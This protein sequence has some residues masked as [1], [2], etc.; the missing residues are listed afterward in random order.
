M[1]NKIFM[2]KGLVPLILAG[3]LTLMANQECE[4]ASTPEKT[5][6]VKMVNYF[7]KIPSVRLDSGV[8]I[9][10]GDFDK[11]GDLDLIEIAIDY[12]TAE[13]RS[14]F[15]ENDGTGNFTKRMYPKSE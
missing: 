7:D 13:A 12:N 4:T 3:S 1:L 9:V 11:D 5:P 2:R 15:L 14:Y 8:G 6:Q 10:S